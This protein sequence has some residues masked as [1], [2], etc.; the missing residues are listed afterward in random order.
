VGVELATPR[1]SPNKNVLH[2][3]QGGCQNGTGCPESSQRSITAGQAGAYGVCGRPPDDGAATPRGSG[4][5]RALRAAGDRLSGPGAGPGTRDP[6]KGSGRKSRSG[7][8]EK[9]RGSETRRGDGRQATSGSDAARHYAPAFD[10]H[11]DNGGT[12]DRNWTAGLWRAAGVHLARNGCGA[13][14]ATT[15]GSEAPHRP[16][17]GAEAQQDG[18]QLP[19]EPQRCA[20]S[21]LAAAPDQFKQPPEVAAKVGEGY[22][23]PAEDAER[24][25][26]KRFVERIFPDEDFDVG[27]SMDQDTAVHRLRGLWR[28]LRHEDHERKPPYERPG[29]RRTPLPAAVGE[30]YLD[31]QGLEP[32]GLEEDVGGF[33]YEFS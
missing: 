12:S 7:G 25:I 28:R 1:G 33:L 23:A 11:P 21:T 14:G 5:D 8:I 13:R 31:E 4:G 15:P 24:L 16:D 19:N 9:T 22:V 27:F 30:E 26:A 20:Q 3:L 17:R 32:M 2:G 6:Q 10:A 29:L 18:N